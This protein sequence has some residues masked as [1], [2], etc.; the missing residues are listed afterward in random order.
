MSSIKSEQG[1]A[2]CHFSFLCYIRTLSPME[3]MKRMV[4]TFD[5]YITKHHLQA[6]YGR[7]PTEVSCSLTLVVDFLKSNIHVVHSTPSPIFCHNFCSL[8]SLLLPCTFSPNHIQTYMHSFLRGLIPQ[9]IQGTSICQIVFI[10]H[11]YRITHIIA[12]H[13][14][15]IK[16]DK[17]FHRHQCH[18]TGLDCS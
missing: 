15:F 8:T 7:F 14:L 18:A 10:L 11:F 3:I 2:P 16:R 5:C 9:S 17:H 4:Y 1:K 13:F 6:V 12:Q